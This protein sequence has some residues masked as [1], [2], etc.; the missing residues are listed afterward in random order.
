[1]AVK[2]PACRITDQRVWLGIVETTLNEILDEV[3]ESPRLDTAGSSIWLARCARAD[4]TTLSY[5]LRTPSNCGGHAPALRPP[6]S[7]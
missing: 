2:C 7:H 4:R 3:S 6:R 1:M 5:W